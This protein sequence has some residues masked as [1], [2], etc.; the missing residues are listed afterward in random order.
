[1]KVYVAASDRELARTWAKRLEAEGHTITSRWL[2]DGQWKPP[3][4]D[5][6]ERR[7]G[8]LNDHEDVENCEVL[9]LQAD[10]QRK[11]VGGGKHVEMGIALAL[12]KPCFVV[13]ERGNIFHWHPLVKMVPNFDALVPELKA[14]ERTKDDLARAG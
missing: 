6:T 12:D 4:Y 14:Y 1:M 8:A 10:D 5:D 3:V 13:G 7:R 9:I 11:C 2:Y